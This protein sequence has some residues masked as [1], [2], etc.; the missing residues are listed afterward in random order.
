MTS[1]SF[2]GMHDQASTILAEID[3]GLIRQEKLSGAHM[4]FMREFREKAR[5]L[6]QLDTPPHAGRGAGG[7]KWGACGHQPGVQQSRCACFLEGIR[8]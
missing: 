3:L 5:E 7:E 8:S 1:L 2:M 6:G 4:V